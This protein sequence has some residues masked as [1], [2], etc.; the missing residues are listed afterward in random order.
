MKF[1]L[2]PRKI[3]VLL[4]L[5]LALTTTETW[6]QGTDQ[7][8]PEPVDSKT[9]EL[10]MGGKTANDGSGS[11]SMVWGPCLDRYQAR[12]RALREG[13]MEAWLVADSD[14]DDNEAIGVEKL[15]R[16]RRS[17][18]SGIRAL[19]ETLAAELTVVNAEDGSFRTR[20]SN[21]LARRRALSVCRPLGAGKISLDLIDQVQSVEPS[22][23]MIRVLTPLLTSWDAEMRRELEIITETMLDLDAEMARLKVGS[24]RSPI[25]NDDPD[26]SWME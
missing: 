22:E 8:F 21:R 19:D 14:Q 17:I 6:A 26:T 2:Q 18:L 20:L 12:F 13:A 5:T 15:T 11:N 4:L 24:F 9:L 23:E 25:E 16:D 7:A 3:C 1:T 10:W